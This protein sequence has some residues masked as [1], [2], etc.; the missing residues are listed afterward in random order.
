MQLSNGNIAAL[1]CLSLLSW[2]V[3]AANPVINC[4]V[5]DYGHNTLTA[6][7]SSFGTNPTVTLGPLILAVQSLTATQLV[8]SFPVP[9]SNLAPG[10][11]SLTITF[12]SQMGVVFDLAVGAIG[13]AGPIGPQGPIGPTGAP[14]PQGPIGPPGLQG[15]QGPQGVAGPTG[16]TGPTGPAGPQGPAGPGGLNGVLEVAQGSTLTSFVVPAGI[17]KLLVEAYGGGGGGGNGGLAAVGGGGGAGAYARGVITVTPGDTL[18][19]TVGSGGAGSS[20]VA[21]GSGGNGEPTEIADGQTIL[22]SAGG[23]LGGGSNSSSPGNGGVASAPA[24]VIIHTGLD[25]SGANGAAGYPVIGFPS[26][27]SGGGAGGAG[28]GS[29]GQRGYVLLI[30]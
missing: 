9:V 22:V 1:F 7:G 25:G 21:G 14:G 27:V 4:V 15:S 20:S 24:G 29:N 5:V 11:Y 17:S 2:P 8:A 23:G 3:D 18:T 30:W 10:T 13:P 12:R 6:S 26:P 19:I 16:P 28:I